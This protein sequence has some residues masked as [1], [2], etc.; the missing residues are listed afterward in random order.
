MFLTIN[1]LEKIHN[2]V[3][4]NLPFLGNGTKITEFINFSLFADVKIQGNWGIDFQ[5]AK[6]N[7]NSYHRYSSH[8]LSKSYGKDLSQIPEIDLISYF[9]NKEIVKLDKHIFS[10]LKQNELNEV[11]NYLIE[12]DS[13]IIKKMH[14]S[15]LNNTQVNKESKYLI[16]FTK[17]LLNNYIN[18]N[19]SSKYIDEKLFTQIIESCSSTTHQANHSIVLKLLTRGAEDGYDKNLILKNLKVFLNNNSVL[20]QVSLGF[21][22]K[23]KELIVDWDFTEHFTK[24][25][26]KSLY[27]EEAGYLSKEIEGFYYNID[28]SVLEKKKKISTHICINNIK[29]FLKHIPNILAQDDKFVSINE[30][31]NHVKIDINISFEKGVDPSKIAALNTVMESIV[32]SN[33]FLK[34][35]YIEG[36]LKSSLLKVFLEN[37]LYNEEK[38]PKVKR[39]KI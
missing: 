29:N 26:V 23:L 36:M 9:N 27:R 24:A 16:L 12:K 8:Y 3:N 35:D 15:V 25:E 6:K 31:I 37:T 10:G 18:K 21:L 20:N 39:S 2:I 33:V 38:S 22:D 19:E 14:V 7:T 13:D 1:D 17:F 11:L 28:A 4:P 30:S 32:F 34:E 5:G